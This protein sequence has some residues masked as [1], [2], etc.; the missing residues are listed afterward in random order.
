[1]VEALERPGAQQR[2]LARWEALFGAGQLGGWMGR[3]AEAQAYL[4]ECLAI[5]R[6]L[7]DKE[8]VA[9]VLQPLGLAALG[10][11]SRSAARGYFEEALAL[12]RELGNR[13][14]L[15]A[16]LN[17]LAQLHRMEGE[18]DKA[19]PLYHD[20]LALARELGD[21]ESIAVAL[22]NLAMV[23][24]A[25]GFGDRVRAGLR[26]VSSIVEEIGS[27]PMAQSVLEVCAGLAAFRGQWARAA[28]L[29]GAVEAHA[30]RTGLH[31][32]PADQAFL[33]PLIA[34]ARGALGSV[35]FASAEA[36]GRTLTY[37][38]VTLEARA[39]LEESA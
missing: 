26:E 6:E 34:K 10:Q 23:S 20:V 30:E 39:W 31:R 3:Y 14:E 18:L 4:E 9:S 33:A 28:R 1:M 35:A 11:G 5:A 13:R 19:E 15:A 27:K 7:D 21:R 17:A 24:I 8:R 25:R 32:D 12:A 2:S 36:A 29:F 16:A 38:K 22:L 37:E